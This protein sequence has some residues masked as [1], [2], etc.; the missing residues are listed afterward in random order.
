MSDTA[1]KYYDEN[2]GPSASTTGLI[3]PAPLLYHTY[4]YLYVE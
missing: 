3:S 2:R 1:V 4:A